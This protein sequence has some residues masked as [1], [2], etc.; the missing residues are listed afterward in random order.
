LEKEGEV[1]IV[2]M[3][4][5]MKKKEVTDKKESQ[6]DKSLKK[7]KKNMGKSNRINKKISI[8]KSCFKVIFC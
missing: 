7:T 6:K 4:M 8:R 2:R 3:T 1:K 5:T